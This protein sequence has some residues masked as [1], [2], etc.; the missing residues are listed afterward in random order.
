MRST[1]ATWMPM[2]L[3]RI[4]KIEILVPK[5]LVCLRVQF[6]ELLL[7]L[8]HFNVLDF[9]DSIGYH[10]RNG[11]RTKKFAYEVGT[12]LGEPETAEQ[13]YARLKIELQE[14]A[15]QVNDLKVC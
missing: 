12:D 10:R 13:R 7:F 5:E 9:S 15:Q 14:L 11:Y 3:L 2:P 1:E 8:K 6:F 4:S